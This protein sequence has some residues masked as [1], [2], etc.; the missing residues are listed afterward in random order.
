MFELSKA[1]SAINAI[2]LGKNVHVNRVTC[3][4]R[5]VR[6]GDLFVALKGQ[7]FDA[8]KFVGDAFESG[9]VA[10]MVHRG[11]QGNFQQPLLVVDDDTRLGFGKLAAWW[12]KKFK[13]PVIAVT[14]SNGKTTVKEMITAILRNCD[15]EETVLATAGNLNNDIGVPITLVQIR[16]CHKYAVIE[17]G[18]NNRGEIEYLSGITSPTMGLITNAGSAHI[19][20]L[21]SISEVAKAKGELV[22]GLTTG[23]KIILNLDDPSVGR[24]KKQAKGLSVVG[25]G[26]N[27]FSDV[28]ATFDLQNN[29]SEVDMLV[30][31]K[32]CKINLN[33]PG[34]HNVRNAMAAAAVCSSLGISNK[35][36]SVGLEKYVGVAGRL[37]LIDLPGNIRLY[38]DSYNA[39]PDSMKA[40]LTVF[41]GLEGLK[42]FIMGDMGELGGDSSE[43]HKDIGGFAKEIGVDRLFG[44]GEAV[45]FSVEGFG[46]KSNQYFS[47]K[48]LLQDLIMVLQPGVNILVKGSRSCRLET[49]VSDIVG[50]CGL[51]F[52]E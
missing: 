7:R 27:D 46:G 51:N 12:R 26:F 6:Q 36:I 24:W 2:H 5:S 50:F 13:I 38:D 4:S 43:L 22:D 48:D 41:S 16:E 34:I 23:S 52:S 17:M 31:G 47:K 1:A 40:A 14:G 20:N 25:F 42:F 15:G 21:G 35:D 33:V 19:G 44:F 32:P 49:L 37:R 9:A 8:H 39:N 28:S 11:W 29:R 30:F 18:M 3:D 10:A 45:A